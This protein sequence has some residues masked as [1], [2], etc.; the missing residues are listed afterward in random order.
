MDDGGWVELAVVYEF[1]A[2][3]RNYL[4]NMNFLPV[5]GTPHGKLPTAEQ[6]QRSLGKMKVKRIS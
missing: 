5:G 2:V 6:N 3:Q 4:P 1:S